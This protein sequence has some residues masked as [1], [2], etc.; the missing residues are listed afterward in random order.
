[1]VDGLKVVVTGA[2]R[3]IGRAIAIAYAEH[4][5]HLALCGI[6][7]LALEETSRMCKQKGAASTLAHRCDVSR[8]DDVRAFAEHLHAEL[9]GVDVVVHNAGVVERARIDETTEAAWDHVVDVN[10]K[11]PYLLTHALLP[12]MRERRCGRLVFIASISAT[13][14]TPRLSAYC[15]SKHGVI[16]F[17]RAA[18]EELREEGIYSFAVNPGSVDTDM[19]KGS[20]F[21]PQVT[22]EEIA[23]VVVWLGTDAPGTMTGSTIDVFG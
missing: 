22:P 6:D 17:M 1:M 10:L 9:G 8:H 11:G 14:G 3:G 15:A 2:S 13:L 19:L 20:G 5:A 7:V 16:G 21:P 12:K 18:A 4:G 23:S